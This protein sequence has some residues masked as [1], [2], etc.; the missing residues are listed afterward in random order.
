MKI[1]HFN[2]DDYLNALNEN[3]NAGAD[4]VNKEGLIIPDENKKSYDWLQKEY[5]KGKTEVKVEIKMGGSKF[6]PGYDLQTDVKTTKDFKPGMYGDVKTSDTE[7]SK[8]EKNESSEGSAPKDLGGV[9]IKAVSKSSDKKE[10]KEDKKD[11]KEDK[12]EE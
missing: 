3:E 2:I 11:K 9:K 7:G 6:E 1:G 4:K 8:K 5:N 10:K 12:T